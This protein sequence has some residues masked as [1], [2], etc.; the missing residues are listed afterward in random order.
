MTHR[1]WRVCDVA[2]DDSVQAVSDL[3][4]PGVQ[5]SQRAEAG[6]LWPREWE[7]AQHVQPQDQPDRPGQPRD[8]G[9]QDPGQEAPP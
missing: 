7:W 1:A 5:S 9:D 8:H 6:D 4:D 2:G 3:P